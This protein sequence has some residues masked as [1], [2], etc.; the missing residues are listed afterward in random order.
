MDAIDTSCV[1]G[2]LTVLFTG[3]LDMQSAPALIAV[4]DQQLT[5]CRPREVV[6]D[7]SALT[8]LDSTGIGLLVGYRNQGRSDGFDVAVVNSSTRIRRLFEI[9]A[10]TRWFGME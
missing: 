10:L 2:R 4:V 7:M 3:E 9:N 1:S 5:D 8:F 6:F